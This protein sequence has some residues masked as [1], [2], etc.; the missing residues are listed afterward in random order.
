MQY[1]SSK[2]IGI[3]PSFEKY[4]DI[5]I[6]TPSPSYYPVECALL[7]EIVYFT[8]FDALFSA[9]YFSNNDFKN[10]I[11]NKTSRATYLKI[12]KAFDK[13]LHYEEQ[14][15]QLN[16]AKENQSKKGNPENKILE[17]REKIK[18]T[19]I[20]TQNIIILE[21]FNKEYD[22]ITNLEELENYRRKLSKFD[23]IVGTI[24]NYTFYEDYYIKMMNKLEHKSN[25]LEN[26]GIETAIE[27]KSS[28]IFAILS[29][30]KN[31]LSLKKINEK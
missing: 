4:Y 19:F 2:I 11:I 21:F 23:A 9:T 24:D 10:I 16:S 20:D 13:I 8:G 15:I 29:K 25:V 6:Y 7:N 5:N 14:I 12:Q 22:R 17:Y 18:S 28:P 27:V 26:G 30:I 1:I 3:E 31:L